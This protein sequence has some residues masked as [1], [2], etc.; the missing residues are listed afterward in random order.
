MWDCREC[1][2]SSRSLS[3]LR[4]DGAPVL[5]SSPDT[6]SA[7]WG[8]HTVLELL[9]YTPEFGLGEVV[10]IYPGPQITVTNRER[11]LGFLVFFLMSALATSKNILLM[12]T[13]PTCL[14][15]M[16]IPSL[17]S[18]HMAL[19]PASTSSSPSN[20]L[21]DCSDTNLSHTNHNR[22]NQGTQ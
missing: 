1:I 4:V 3:P 10:E 8:D 6:P 7:T 20:S 14:T 12:T 16:S 9:L 2:C 13:L 15:R 18:I 19:L 21:F 11:L 17:L 5:P 22:V